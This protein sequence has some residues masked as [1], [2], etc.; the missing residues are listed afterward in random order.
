[1][2]DVEAPLRDFLEDSDRLANGGTSSSAPWRMDAVLDAPPLDS[3]QRDGPLPASFAQERL[4]FLDQL[5]PGH[6][7]YNIP[8]AVSLV[9]RLD[10]SAL[11]QALNDVV[12]RHEV[13]RTTLV[14]EKGIPRQ[15]IAASLELPLEHEDLSSLPEDERQS[16]RR[17]SHARGS[18]S[19]RS[20]WLADRLSVPVCCDWASESTSPW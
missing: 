12:R 2:F 3:V 11:E 15:V 17:G 19:G 1:M 8:A 10:V 20:T 9:G 5:E 13:L 18:S 6:A 14:S 4:W 16:A 7:S